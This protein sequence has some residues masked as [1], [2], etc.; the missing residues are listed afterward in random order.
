MP[1]QR[2]APIYPSEMAQRN[3]QETEAAAR[4]LKYLME[5]YSYRQD[6]AWWPEHPEPDP[7]GRAE[8]FFYRP[9][10]LMVRRSELD[11]VVRVLDHL[12]VKVCGP[13]PDG[14]EGPPVRLLVA[15]R[16]PIPVLLRRLRC[17][18]LEADVVGPNH[19]FWP[20]NNLG[21]TPW[22][23]GGG[24]SLPAEQLS[25]PPLAVPPARGNGVTA[26]VFDSG[27]LPDWDDQTTGWHWLTDVHPTRPSDV[28]GQGGDEDGPELDIYDSHATFVTGVLKRT[29][30]GV[31]VL[32]R[33]VL[34]ELGAV[35]DH[36]L[37]DAIRLTL[38]A[39]PAQLVNLSLG[40]T[41]INDT[42]PLGLADL[43]SIEFPDVVFVAAAGNNG[44]GGA[45]FWPAAL[46]RV[47]GVGALTDATPPARAGFSNVVS[48]DVWAVGQDV[49][50]AFGRGWLVHADGK[51]EY[52]TGLAAWSGTSFAAPLVTG[53][54]CEYVQGTATP[55]GPGALAWLQ[56]RGLTTSSML[57]ISA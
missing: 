21:G 38:Q 46:P 36:D 43:V 53:V 40:G 5:E 18:G 44:P 47:V 31:K 39:H 25:L 14:G 54:L 4:R 23:S 42:P 26:V 45:R 22:L 1:P 20:S 48:A 16:D 27:L 34:N 52:T 17:Y 28:E 33:N 35:D 8:L 15:S 57:V 49:V 37:C 3:R 6:V 11:V 32:V 24:G 50:N 13:R 51:K 56:Q 29:A 19:V 12:G 9:G 30:P 41:T 2:A 55:S 10:Q 7:C